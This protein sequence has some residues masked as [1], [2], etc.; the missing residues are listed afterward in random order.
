LDPLRVLLLYASSDATRT[1]SYQYGWPRAF[2]RHP[3]FRCTAVN[4]ADPRRRAR[5][6]AELVVRARR[7][8]AIV[9]LHSVYS[10]APALEGPLFELVCRLPQPKAF[11]IGNEYKLMPEKM[12]Y[13]EQLGIAL[14]VTQ[15]LNPQVISLY[16][17][18]LSCPV[19]GI[20]SAGFDPTLFVPTVP[21]EDRPVDVGYRAYDTPQYLGHDERRLLAEGFRAAGEAAGLTLDISLDPAD[22]LDEARWADFLNNSK[23]QLGSEA[24]GDYFELTDQTRFRVDRYLREHPDASR[25]EL[26]ERFFRGYENPV[27]MRAL[28]GRISEAAGTK[29]VQILLEGEYAGYFEPDVHYIP[30]RKDLAN[31]GEAIAKLRDAPFARDLAQ[32]AYEV[33]HEYLTYE[34]LIDRFYEAFAPL[35]R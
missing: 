23:A 26:F 16:R 13:A 24:G 10:N 20:P 19:V 15:S 35:V 21:W 9:L 11:F 3:R 33:A 31:A 4:V 14:L 12:R 34:R 22:R 8:D 32:R 2:V 1:L 17:A 30:L 18:R 6:R 25:Q 28:S 5:L 27:P 7:F 29:T